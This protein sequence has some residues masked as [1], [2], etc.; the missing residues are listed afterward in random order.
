MRRL[1]KSVS[2]S[3]REKYKPKFEGK[4]FFNFSLLVAV[5]LIFSLLV[6]VMKVSFMFTMHCSGTL[7]RF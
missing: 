6:A 1:Y 3:K 5:I 2:G 7:V 4:I